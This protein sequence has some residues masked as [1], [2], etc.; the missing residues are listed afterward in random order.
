[1]IHPST[2][3][4][5]Y[6]HFEREG[7]G[8]EI[9][10]HVGKNA[11]RLLD[12]CAPT[13]LYLVDPYRRGDL[14]VDGID[15]PIDAEEA[16]RQCAARFRGDRRA[17]FRRTWS[18]LWLGSID[19]G[20]LDWAY[21]D[22]DHKYETT[23]DELVLLAR[24]VKPTGIIAGHDYHDLFGGVKQAVDEFVAKGPWSLTYLTLDEPWPSFGLTCA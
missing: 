8:A 9:G 1:M 19:D 12:I 21:V 13:R 5:L 2:R 20:S 7:I 10:V 11:A 16:M 15:L 24:K 3:E 17:L 18:Q 23:R 6:Q 4:D 22:S 14:V